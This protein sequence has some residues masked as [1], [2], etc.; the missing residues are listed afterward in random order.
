MESSLRTK[1]VCVVLAFWLA[2]HT[3]PETRL[4]YTSPIPS[5]VEEKGVQGTGPPSVLDLFKSPQPY[6]YFYSVIEKD[7]DKFIDPSERLLL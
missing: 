4:I 2:F 1:V 6:G 3:L 7:N 5:F